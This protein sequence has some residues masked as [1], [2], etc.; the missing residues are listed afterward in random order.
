M[1]TIPK[2]LTLIAL[3][4][5]AVG[6]S[7][8]HLRVQVDT[9]P[10]VAL[11]EHKTIVIPTFSGKQGS[12][13]SDKLISTFENIGHYDVISKDKLRDLLTQHNLTTNDLHNFDKLASVAE[14][15]NAVLISGST[16]DERYNQ[17]E[18]FREEVCF[19]LNK[20]KPKVATC[21]YNFAKGTWH[22]NL[23]ID[24]T[25]LSN[26]T[27]LASKFYARSNTKEAKV[28]VD[29]NGNKAPDKAALVG[30][31]GTLITGGGIAKG[32][33]QAAKAV[34]NNKPQINWQA[35][36]YSPVLDPSLAQFMSLLKPQKEGITLTLYKDKSLPQ[37]EAGIKHAKAREW[38]KAIEKF[39]EA[40]NTA[41]QSPE[42][43]PE[44]KAKS[45]YNLGV[46]YG[47][48]GDN[49]EESLDFIEQA[50]DTLPE[51]E[52][53]E[54]LEKIKQIERYNQEMDKFRSRINDKNALLDQLHFIIQIT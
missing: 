43:K 21:Y 28:K 53:Y 1:N 26:G 9:P 42:I 27:K 46:I 12:A 22:A 36:D 54:S 39:R 48:T 41:K 6:C 52:F 13:V 18:G 25:A 7:T 4:T 33:T 20:L 50:T 49:Y 10:T 19:E 32:L 45:F 29:K 24:A 38:R 23:A 34:A 3:F 11:Y 30:A 44:W 40:V 17:E 5:S 14:L 47:L 15:D 2:I 37:L 16:S 51:T 31:L 35:S 8:S